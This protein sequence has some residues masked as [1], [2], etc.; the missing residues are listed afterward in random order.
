[1][2]LSDDQ[3]QNL[4]DAFQQAL[5]S[6]MSGPQ[7]TVSEL[8]MFGALSREHVGQYNAQALISVEECLHD[9]IHERCLAQ[10]SAPA[11]CAWDGD[12]TYAQ[13]DQMSSILAADLMRRGVR[14]DV[15]VPLCFEKSRWTAIA[16]LGIVKAGG[17]FVLLD[18]SFPLLRLQ[19]ICQDTNASLILTSE[20]KKNLAATLGPEVVVVSNNSM[21][22]T[23]ESMPMLGSTSKPSNALYAVFTSGSVSHLGEVESF[24]SEYHWIISFECTTPCET[25]ISYNPALTHKSCLNSKSLPN[26]AMLTPPDCR[27]VSP[28]GQ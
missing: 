7:Q 11:V 26:K 16:L 12:F 23:H 24:C 8:D 5:L 1:V 6:I 28:K 20:S 15:F 4:G 22:W 9:L 17:A 19:S 18:P 2:F 21:R 25:L 27:V 3:A 13:L 10:P 14:P